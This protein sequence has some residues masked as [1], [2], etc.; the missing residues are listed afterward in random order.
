MTLTLLSVAALAPS[1]AWASG[2]SA[3]DQQYV[4]PLAGATTPSSSRPPRSSSA[5]PPSTASSAP[6]VAAAPSSAASAAAA[7]TAATTAAAPTL[8]FTGLDAAETFAAGTLLLG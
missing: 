1:A 4:D 3:G 6:A 8:P 7:P 5:S 2:P